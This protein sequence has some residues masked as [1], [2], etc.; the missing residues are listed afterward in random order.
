MRDRDQVADRYRDRDAIPCNW[1]RIRRD[2]STRQSVSQR[3]LSFVLALDESANLASVID[4]RSAWI[5]K[6]V[7]NLAELA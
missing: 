7:R 4:S 6:R 3:R 2:R 5:D 1:H